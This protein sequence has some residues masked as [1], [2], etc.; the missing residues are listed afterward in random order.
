M[1][2][3]ILTDSRLPGIHIF[4]C[5]ML[6]LITAILNGCTGLSAERINKTDNKTG[7]ANPASVNCIDKGGV[8]SIQKRGDGGEYG[9]CIFE[10]NSQCEEW[11][12]FRGECSAGGKAAMKKRKCGW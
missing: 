12:L 1:K 10:D 8:L 2:A 6:I 3:I 5:L 7:I 4:G 11:A 9:I